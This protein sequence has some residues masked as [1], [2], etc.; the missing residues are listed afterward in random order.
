MRKQYSASL[1]EC[2]FNEEEWA[3]L[4]EAEVER[5]CLTED[6]RLTLELETREQSGERWRD[7][8]RKRITGSKCAPGQIMKGTAP[9]LKLCV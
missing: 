2:P 4:A 8:R 7:A 1:I 5:L 6:D 9:L 3:I